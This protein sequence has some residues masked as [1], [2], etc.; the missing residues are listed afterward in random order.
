MGSVEQVLN[1]QLKQSV[2]AKLSHSY[3][4]ERFR[5]PKE[6]SYH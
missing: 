3:H 1:F 6:E 5:I 4:R 2:A